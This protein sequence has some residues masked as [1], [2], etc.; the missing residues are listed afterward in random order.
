MLLAYFGGSAVSAIIFV[1]A[2]AFAVYSAVKRRKM[3]L[4]AAALVLGLLVTG[5]YENLYCK[6]ILEYSGKTISGE[7]TVR[8]VTYSSGD[9]QRVTAVMSLG[10]KT[11]KVSL[12]CE[13]ELA[14]GQRAAAEI[15]LG[16]YDEE[17]L[18]YN[19]A[20][21]ILLSGSAENIKLVSTRVTSSGFLQT[22]RS[23]LIGA[24]EQTVFG[25]ERAL[26][27]AMV[28]GEDGELSQVTREKLRIC[29]AAHY[30]A[31]SGAHF[32]VFGTVLT[33]LIPN[34]RKR[35]KAA[36]PLVFAPVA[37]LFFGT[38]ASVLRAAAMFFLSGLASLFKRRSE[39]LNTLCAAFTA[40]A[41]CSPG[42]ILDAGFAM[43]ALGVLGAG[44]IG[45][46]LSERLCRQLPK[47]AGFL[48]TPI[49]VIAASI[50]AVICTSPVSA[51]IFKGVSL[52][53]ALTSILLIPLMTIGAVFAMI[54]GI[55]GSPLLAVPAVYAMRAAGWIIGFF[56]S[57][58]CR[59][60]WLPLDFDGA[61]VLA[62]LFAVLLVIGT[63]A[64]P[65][66]LSVSV[67]CMSAL[68]IFSISMSMRTVELQSE[69]RFTGNSKSSAAVVMSGDIASVV[70]S[71][72]GAGLTEKMSQTLRE[73]G[74]KRI[75]IL[76][77]ESADF[78]GALAV[79]E[80]SELIE[81]DTIYSTPTAAAVLADREVKPISENSVLN[82][83]GVTIAAAH[84]SE[85]DVNA[86]IAVY[87]GDFRKVPESSADIA[88][89]FS[90]YKRELPVNG[91]N[92]S[93][94]NAVIKLPSG[95]RITVEER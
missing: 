90:N 53:G 58:N 3:W 25:D 59:C 35:L 41:L 42:I 65:K 10:G 44:V 7:F 31:V 67:C 84:Y 30:T 20:N 87:H 93:R 9:L 76:M 27:L 66:A 47:K 32:A 22:L 37:V 71:G 78:S 63:F 57:K 92:A 79:K 28:F 94:D 34:K 19:L 8:E 2:A 29:G 51:A 16:E 36:F 55:T 13:N 85:S 15:E 4:C 64:S 68:A 49:T 73:S 83:G 24:V 60:L 12:Y 17:R 82:V 46:R 1:C 89:Y 39:T 91:I 50:S 21:G 86:D 88:V 56:G 80:L 48:S 75:S 54:A 62:A 6:P 70:I 52:T 26:L 77:A 18:L 33:L 40:I 61:W 38:S 74:A 69:I 14:V 43:S 23:E 5:L 45:P 95:S 11:A 81:I 72:T